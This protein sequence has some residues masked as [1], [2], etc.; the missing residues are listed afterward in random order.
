MRLTLRTMLA[1]LDGNLEPDDTEDIGKKIEESEFATT[2]VHRTRDCMRRLRLGVPAL[3]G[4][5]LAADP[6]TVAEYLEYELSDERVPEFEKIC[7]ESDVHLAEVASCHQIL[8]LV[9]REPA[10]IDP[11]ARQRMYRLAA[12]VDAPPVQSDAVGV[13]SAAAGSTLATGAKSPPP[14][15]Q[16]GLRR[17][18]PE[19]PEYLRESRSRFWPVAAT[20]LVAALLTFGGLM[21]F[22]GPAQL[23]ESVTALVQ[24]PD[25][26]AGAQEDAEAAGQ[27]EVAEKPP[28]ADDAAS[29]RDAEDPTAPASAEADQAS[30]TKTSG[31]PDNDS[32]QSVPPDRAIDDADAA[33]VP[34]PRDLAEADQTGNKTS[35]TARSRPTN[36]LRTPPTPASADV[37]PEE[38][39]RA[40]ATTSPDETPDKPAGEDAVSD[41]DGAKGAGFGRYTSKHETS[42]HEVLLQ[43]DPESSDWI[44]LPDMWPLSKGD[45]LQSLPSFRPAITLSSG[46]TIRADGPARFDLIGWSD[47]GVPIVAVVYGRFSMATAGK[48]GN[49]LQLKFGEQQ[50]QLTFVDADSTLTLE[51]RRELPPGKDPEMD[52]VP[53]TV[54]LYATSGLIR[55]REGETPIELQA[56]A[57]R[58]LFA[59]N[60][61]QP[62]DNE[63]PKWVTSDVTSEVDRLATTTLEPLLPPE[64]SVGLTLKELADGQRSVGR[65]REVRSLAIRSLSCLGEFEACV[66]ALNDVK[67][68]QFWPAAIDDLRLAVARS[69]E[70]A[71][72]VRAA[73]EKQRNADAAALYR[74][75]WGYSA[76]DLKNGA[77]RDLVEGLD[78]ESLDLRVLSFWNL[79]NI[80]GSGN[81]GYRPEDLAAKRRT[82]LNAWKEKLRQG[83]IVPRTA[84]ASPKSKAAGKGG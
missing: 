42:K 45:Q 68:K 3:F 16:V 35:A 51:A 77:D 21:A 2:L 52:P 70:T 84:T 31:A 29:T 27:A 30:P 23:R 39:P 76:D 25:N 62:A 19:V 49:S 67:E 28:A 7:L 41:R 6:N 53:L 69:P 64:K 9:L 82:P 10:E 1:Y 79:Q 17:A 46:M 66:G 20:L 74:M 59:T 83:K 50:T 14:V 61:E 37:P 57:H 36:P 54:H 75:L 80:M 47:Q 26:E 56:P 73:L 44:R 24:A 78:K 18:R 72:Q 33:P 55:I 48:A 60:A 13:A 8:T 58:I 43:F 4:R 15:A 38:K 34:E 81:H 40:A 32:R 63:F 71:A 11:A 65:R 12:H 5:G 22:I